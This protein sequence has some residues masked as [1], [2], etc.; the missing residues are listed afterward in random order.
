VQFVTLS[1]IRA[2]LHDSVANSGF[3]DDCGRNLRC[4]SGLDHL[5]VAGAAAPP[6]KIHSS[7]PACVNERSRSLGTLARVVCFRSVGD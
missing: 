6:A 7:P 1:Q 5:L 3:D 4:R 2:F